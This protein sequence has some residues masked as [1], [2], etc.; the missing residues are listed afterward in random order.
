MTKIDFKTLYAEFQRDL[1]AAT[2]IKEWQNLE[3]K[4]LGK[5]SVIKQSFAVLKQLSADEKASYAA[6]INQIAAQIKQDLDAAQITIQTKQIQ[7]QLA[8]EWIDTSLPG[9]SLSRGSLHP[10]TQTANDC[11]AVFRRLGFSLVDGNEVETAFYNF[12]A[13]NIPEHHPAREMQDTFWLEKGLLLRSHTTTV[14]ARIL[15]E[16]RDLPIKVVSSGRVYRNEAIDATH[17][18]MFHQ[19]EGVW[20]DRGITFAD[21][22]GVIS[23]IAHELYGDRPLRIVPKYYPY[24]EPSIGMDIQCGNCHG[25]GCVSCH[26]AGWITLIG[27]GMIHRNVL[28]RFGYDPNEVQGFAFGWGGTRMAAQKFGVKKIKDLYEQDLRLFETLRK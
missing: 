12:D 14:Q 16:K 9:T 22:K 26:S 7:Q 6:E 15:E 2:S 1:S 23:F 5:S 13:L 25:L 18:A 10:F 27:A 3:K 19:I 24:T 4:Y 28:Q 8:K 11:F 20:V 17:L 21:L